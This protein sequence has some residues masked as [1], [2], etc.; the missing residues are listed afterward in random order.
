MTAEDLAAVQS[1]L[2]RFFPGKEVWVFGSRAHGTAHPFSDLDLVIQTTHPIPLSL[3]A[4]AREA[5]SASRL[6]FEV[7]LLDWS[8][9]EDNFK[10]L[11]QAKHSVL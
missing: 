3:L 4:D 10:K 1:L 8:R 9:I 11:I 6:P 5:F 7:D 2:Q